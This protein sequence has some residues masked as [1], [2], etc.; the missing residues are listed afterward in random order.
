[1]L[2]GDSLGLGPLICVP[3]G[4]HV[5]VNLFNDLETNHTAVRGKSRNLGT[6]PT[7]NLATQIHWHGLH[8]R[9]FPYSDGFP[10]QNQ[11]P[12]PAEGPRGGW[13]TGNKFLTR[14]LSLD[15]C[16]RA[17]RPVHC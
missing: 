10:T 6:R 11:C 9:G 2:V 12:I 3:H 1:M 8:Q 4:S 7:S 5:E 17:T 15:G 16:G 13:N 14:P